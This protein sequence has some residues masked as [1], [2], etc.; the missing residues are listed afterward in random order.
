MKKKKSI[1]IILSVILVGLISF[2]T[3]W[4]FDT[5]DPM[6]ESLNALISDENV[7]VEIGS[8]FIF[9]PKNS[10]PS[11]GIIFYPGAKIGPESYSILAKSIAIKG[12]LVIIAPMPMNL[13]FL[14]TSSPFFLV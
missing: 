2:T 10:T 9:S 7:D 13:A 3:F 12:Y 11:T 5:S 8:W 6:E 14:V 4:V 1:C